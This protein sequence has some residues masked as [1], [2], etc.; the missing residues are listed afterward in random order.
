VI[1]DFSYAYS[2]C[3]LCGYV[4]MGFLLGNRGGPC[5]SRPPYPNG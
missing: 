5:L 1:A 4:G 2:N 3:V